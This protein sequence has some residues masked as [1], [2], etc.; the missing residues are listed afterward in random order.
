MRGPAPKRS[1]SGSR[2]GSGPWPASRN[3]SKRRSPRSKR[4]RESSTRRPSPRRRA[5]SE[6]RAAESRL[7]TLSGLHERRDWASSGVRAV[8]QHFRNDAAVEK[9]DR[10][11]FGVM[12][13]M[14]ETEAAYEKAVEAVLGERMQSVVV[15]DHTE[16]LSAIHYLKESREGRGAFVAVGLRTRHE[17]LA[18]V[19]EE[20]VV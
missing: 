6:L 7:A 1:R 9:E 3:G 15:R 8:L 19:G 2:K 11:I 10:G 18:Y 13:D 20:G 17:E 14:I 4:P 5:E 16:G 12:G